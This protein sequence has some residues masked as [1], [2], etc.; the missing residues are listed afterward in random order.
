MFSLRNKIERVLLIS[1]V[2][3]LV[4]S[5]ISA[6]PYKRSLY[7]HWS[8]LDS[9]CQSSRMEALITESL[10][11][12]TFKTDNQCKVLNGWWYGVYSG[13]FFSVAAQLD[14]DHIVPLKEAHLSGADTWTR[15]QRKAFANDPDNLL[16]VKA[17]ENR[18]KGAKD[19]GKW[20]PS[21]SRYHC[22]YV[23]KWLFVKLKY[24]LEIDT[25]EQKAINEVVSVNCQ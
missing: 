3:F 19:P 17:S 21:D 20:L 6:E 12:V 2:F 23:A 10:N 24:D 13:E 22:I 25:D 5:N 9:D 7:P 1:F 8:D 18:S 16:A 4:A 11:P 15:E 14:I